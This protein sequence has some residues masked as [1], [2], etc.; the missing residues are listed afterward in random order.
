MYGIRWCMAL[1]MGSI[2]V[3]ASIVNETRLGS[4]TTTTT[5][6]LP[7]L[8]LQKICFVSFLSPPNEQVAM[9]K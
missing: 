4:S 6:T 9:L 5:T 8:M 2:A 7:L 3:I 1:A